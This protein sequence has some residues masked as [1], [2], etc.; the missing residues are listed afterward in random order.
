MCAYWYRV[1]CVPIGVG[2]CVLC[3]PIGVGCCVGLLV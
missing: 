1:L 3:V 2:C